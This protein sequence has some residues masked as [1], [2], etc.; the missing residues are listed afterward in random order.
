VIDLEALVKVCVFEVSQ[1]VTGETLQELGN[2]TSGNH[3]M[4]PPGCLL[5]VAIQHQRIFEQTVM[6]VIDCCA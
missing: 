6:P 2:L 1:A 3:V 4:L 5:E